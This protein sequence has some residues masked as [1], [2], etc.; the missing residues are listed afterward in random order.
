MLLDIHLPFSY[1]RER[2]FDLGAPT[3]RP[4]PPLVGAYARALAQEVASLGPE[5]EGH[6]VDAVFF[7]GGY[8]GLL[9]PDTFRDLLRAVRRSFR[10]AGRLRVDGATFPGS[11]D[12]YAA[13]AYLDEGVGSLMF[14]V[15]TLSGRE[16]A[17]L[18]LPNTLQALD[19]SLYV[20][21]SY[22]AA[23]FGLRLPC[24]VAGR[25]REAWEYLA[26]QVNHYR[27]DHVELVGLAAG[28]SGGP[29]PADVPVGPDFF[30]SLLEKGGYR[31]VPLAPGPAGTPGR[32]F[33][34]RVDEPP[35][36]VE[37]W[38]AAKEQDA[39][40]AAQAPARPGA[41][42][43]S[44]PAVTAGPAR[45]AGPTGPER[46]GVGLGAVTVLDGYL[47]RNTSDMQAYLKRA[48]DYRQLLAEVREL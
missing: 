44:G 26:G 48:A 3:A 18:G 46:V 11:L 19:K 21:E 16:A 47:T 34:T 40:G 2:D 12:M 32:R 7:S 8:A 5:L 33:L 41:A 29:D 42:C 22:G 43:P 28:G 13:S 1:W 23:R 9:Y 17:S 20:L 39:G 45:P 15:P 4:T 37:A 6:E 31:E 30:V 36:Y 27:P 25:S 35:A 14:E 10:C 24:D 38:R